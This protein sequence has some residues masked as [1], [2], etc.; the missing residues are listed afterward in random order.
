[1]KLIRFLL[2]PCFVAL[3]STYLVGPIHTAVIAMIVASFGI[4]VARDSLWIWWK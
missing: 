2:H 1:M 4:Y 3:F